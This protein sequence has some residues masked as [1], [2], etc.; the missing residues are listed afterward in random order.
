MNQ[1][2]VTAHMVE[3]VICYNDGL[4]LDGILAYAAYRA[5]PLSAKEKIPSITNAWACDFDLPLEKWRMNTCS[6]C[7]ERL[8]SGD[9]L[10]GWSAS[11]VHADWL[12]FDKY[13]IRRKPEVDQMVRYTKS[14]SVNLGAG[15]QKAIDI[16]FPAMFATSLHWYAVG[17]LDSIGRMLSEYVRAVGK[18]ANKGPGRVKRWDVEKSDN[19][20]SIEHNGSL[21]RTMPLE[22]E[23]VGFTAFAPIRPPYHHR[24]R[25]LM[26]KKPY[27]SELTPYA[28]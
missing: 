5:L 25:F 21:T 7:D 9:A 11:C 4:H 8:F 17:D 6:D 1:I 24:S 19:D 16:A 13:S 26:C 10:W 2:H 15:Q 18:L 27:C 20:Y 22:H 23:S 3:P 12:C 14:P 28:C